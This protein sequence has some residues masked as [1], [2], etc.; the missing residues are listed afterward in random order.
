MKKILHLIPTFEG[1]GAEHQLAMLVN[2]QVEAGFEVHVALLRLGINTSIIVNKVSLHRINSPSLLSKLAVSSL[3]II[4]KEVKPD[5]IQTWLP[6][7]D[8]IGGFL[9]IRYSI[10]WIMTERSSRKS[11]PRLSMRTFVRFILAFFSNAIVANSEKGANYWAI[12]PL[13]NK[14]SIIRNSVDSK[15]I[16]LRLKSSYFEDKS[17]K[18]F[19]CVGR[20]VKG[21]SIDTVIKSFALLTNEKNIRL[22]IVGDGEMREEL[23]DLI[24]VLGLKNRV[25]IVPFMSEWWGFL[26]SSAA[27]ITMS[28]VEGSPNVL[29]EAIA[30]KCPTIVSK[31]E[32]HMEIVDEESTYFIDLFD[33]KELSTIM[34]KII[35]NPDE[36]ISKANKAF[37]CLPN[38]DIY[39]N[40]GLY[41]SVYNSILLK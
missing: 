17:L 1:G 34:L 18:V 19:L 14:I 4:I 39:D 10:P 32:E 6:Q 31:I 20:L 9:S 26:K 3:S 8:I 41:S 24:V 36:S 12:G 37:K 33:V 25:F 27:L 22:L 28:E 23:M 30:A 15:N 40:T 2:Q 29:I 11:Y 16:S 38:Y 21:K 13:K 35:Y 7:M 5:L